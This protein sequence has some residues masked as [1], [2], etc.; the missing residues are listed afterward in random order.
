MQKLQLKLKNAP[1]DV[2]LL[3]VPSSVSS[4]LNKNS[5]GSSDQDKVLD[6]NNL[7]GVRSNCKHQKSLKLLVYVISKSGKPLMPCSC[8]KAKNMLNKGAAKVIKR[9]PFTI[10]L[11]FDCEEKVQNVTLGIDTGYKYIGFSAVSDKKELISGTVELENRCASRLEERKSYR[12]NR[13]NK[14]WYRE[15]RFNNR[16]RS[17]KKG[18]LPPSVSRRFTA[19]LK[20]INKMFKILPISRVIVEVANFDIQKLENPIIEGVQYQQGTMYEYRNKIAYLIAREHGHCQHC[21]KEYIKGNPWRLH[22]IFGRDL[23][24]PEHWALLHEECHKEIHAKGLEKTLR[25][26]KVKSYKDSTFMTIIRS[27]FINEYDYNVTYGYITFQGRIN[28]DLE[29]SH[30]NDAFVIANGTKQVRAKQY[31]LLQTRRHN[32]SI[33]TNRK[34]YRPSIRTSVYKIRPHDLVWYEDNKYEVIGV[35][36]RGKYVG[37][38]NKSKVIP[39]K[40]ITKHYH[41]NTFSWEMGPN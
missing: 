11:N 21:G 5:K 33:Q 13:R 17:K 8:T 27:K 39:T 31:R 41:F 36:S 9:I 14:L 15:P 25:N 10:Q 30:V 32:R 19:H 38:K 26:K 16:V 34:G 6:C 12:R 37:V 2:Q 29:K 3:L 4:D 7:E 18:W 23:D 35:Q 24:R 1:R 40:K 22:H 28:L 20:L